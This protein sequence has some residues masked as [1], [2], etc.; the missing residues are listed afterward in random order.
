V[1]SLDSVSSLDDE[2][3]YEKMMKRSVNRDTPNR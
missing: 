3:V 1:S 2:E